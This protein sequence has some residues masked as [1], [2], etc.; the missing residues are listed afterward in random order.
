MKRLTLTAKTGEKNT[1]KNRRKPETPA[2]NVMIMSGSACSAM[3]NK[4]PCIA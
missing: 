3:M 2:C 1:A 4:N